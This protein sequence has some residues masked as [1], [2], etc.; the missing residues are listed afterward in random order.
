MRAQSEALLRFIEQVEN[1]TSEGKKIARELQRK[2]AKF[3]AQE[4]QAKITREMN[5]KQLMQF[6]KVQSLTRK[7]R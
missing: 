4:R 6:Q 5:E 2:N 7:M 3:D 1:D